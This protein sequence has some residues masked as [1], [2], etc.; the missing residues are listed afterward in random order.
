MIAPMMLPARSG[1][2][3]AF[4]LPYCGLQTLKHTLQSG[5]PFEHGS[6]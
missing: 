1:L 6:G 3:Y 4:Q 5:G 2:A